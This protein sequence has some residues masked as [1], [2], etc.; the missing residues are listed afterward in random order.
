VPGHKR[1]ES[2]S[3]SS[4]KT[5]IVAPRQNRSA[6]LRASKESPPPSSYQCTCPP[7]PRLIPR[8]F[9]VDMFVFQSGHQ[10]VRL[11]RGPLPV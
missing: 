8:V 2:F 4:T 11:C 7:H 9:G 6:L 10:S 5:P 1:R 3:V